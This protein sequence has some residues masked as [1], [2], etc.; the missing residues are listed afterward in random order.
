[1]SGAGATGQDELEPDETYLH[2]ARR[3]FSW[4]D[5]RRDYWRRVDD[6]TYSG[7]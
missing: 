5:A 4:S 1:M 6:H 2:H 3:S 7:Y